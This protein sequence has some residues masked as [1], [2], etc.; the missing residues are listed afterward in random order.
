MQQYTKK[1]KREIRKLAKL[2][3]RRELVEVLKDL[4]SKFG[5]WEDE[6]MDAFELDHEIY[7]YH[8]QK[9]RA[10]FKKYNNDG[11]LDMA[12][13]SAAARGVLEKNELS[14]ELFEL[15]E[16]VIKRYGGSFDRF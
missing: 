2:A 9:S 4:E 10:I 5:D 3:H 7:L 8:V 12:V 11:Q 13:S 15:L 6:E 16:P 14:D 1:I